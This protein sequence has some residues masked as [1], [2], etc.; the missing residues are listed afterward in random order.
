M[1]TEAGYARLLFSGVEVPRA[2]LHI[3]G[4][5]VVRMNYPSRYR[6]TVIL[7]KFPFT[8]VMSHMSL[9][10]A[11]KMSV[12]IYV[13]KCYIKFI[14]NHFWKKMFFL[15]LEL[16]FDIGWQFNFVLKAVLITSMLRCTRVIANIYFIYL[17]FLNKS[18]IPDTYIFFQ[19]LNS[20]ELVDLPLQPFLLTSEEG[21]HVIPP[22]H[23]TPLLNNFSTLRMHHQIY[24]ALVVRE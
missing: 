10:Q 2:L 13:A 8:W 17:S 4:Q 11:A 7:A 1:E 5:P 9:M 18:F 6:R 3:S 12:W 24:T 16:F 15:H 23:V 20:T 14:V 22:I 19:N 21:G